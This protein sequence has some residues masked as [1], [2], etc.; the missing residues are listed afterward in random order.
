MDKTDLWQLTIEAQSGE[1]EFLYN[2]TFIMFPEPVDES[3]AQAYADHEWLR[4]Q[5]LESWE[6]VIETPSVKPLYNYSK[7]IVEFIKSYFYLEYPNNII[8]TKL[9]KESEVQDA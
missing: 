5:D 4:N 8:L 3:L 6:A 1:S 2:G 9:K 7:E